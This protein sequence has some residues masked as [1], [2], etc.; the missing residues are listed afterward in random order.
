VSA[1]PRATVRAHVAT[2]RIET[3]EAIRSRVLVN[4][5]AALPA[6]RSAAYDVPAV[7]QTAACSFTGVEI[8]ANG[9]GALSSFR[10]VPVTWPGASMV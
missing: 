4:A 9:T 5:T 3:A 6:R 7:A 2:R 1:T 8:R 10:I